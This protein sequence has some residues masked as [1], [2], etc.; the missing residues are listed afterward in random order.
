MLLL[1]VGGSGGVL[2]G[3]GVLLFVGGGMSSFVGKCGSVFRVC[4]LHIIGQEGV[5]SRP[6]AQK[7]TS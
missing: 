4:A 1:F 7:E 3:S 6:R 2:L 5:Y